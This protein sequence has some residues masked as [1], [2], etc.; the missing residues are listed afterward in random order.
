VDVVLKLVLDPSPDEARCLVWEHRVTRAVHGI[1]EALRAAG[2]IGHNPVPHVPHE[3]PDRLL[4][5]SRGRAR[6][7]RPSWALVSAREYVP[8]AGVMTAREWGRLTG[9]L[10]VVGS[11]PAALDL[12]AAQPT[13]VLFGLDAEAFLRAVAAPGHPYH[14]RG[15]ILLA[16]ARTLRRRAERAVDAD[17]LPLLVHR[18]LHP[19]NIV[20]G[21]AGPVAVDWAQAGWGTRSDDFAWL[22]VA[23]TRFG[24]PRR[25]LDEV[26]AGY[27]ETGPGPC[28]TPEQI[29]AAGQVR[30]LIC[31]AFS[32]L[33]AGTSPAH[34]REARVELPILDDPD[35]LTPRWTPLFNPALFEHPVLRRPV[36]RAADSPTA[37]RWA[38]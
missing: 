34:L 36:Q 9:L 37:H 2:R 16:L 21:P 18:D 6:D 14:A 38:S 11:A 24:A 7:G 28:P 35:A 29:T 4:G 20:A 13:G 1:G 25:V 26:R 32:I 31:L 22:H 3:A 10:H 5:L 19:L 8:L 17:P 12:V 27:E 33:R 23:V 15:D 30:E